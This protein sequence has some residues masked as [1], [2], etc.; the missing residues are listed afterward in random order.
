MRLFWVLGL[1]SLPSSALSSLRDHMNLARMGKHTFLANGLILKAFVTLWLSVDDSWICI[2]VALTSS[3]SVK[4]WH[5]TLPRFSR[6]STTY[7]KSKLFPSI[8]VYLNPRTF[9]L[10]KVCQ[11]LVRIDVDST[12][13]HPE[14]HQPWRFRRCSADCDKEPGEEQKRGSRNS[15]DYMGY[16][17]VWR[18]FGRILYVQEGWEAGCFIRH[19]W[20]SALASLAPSSHCS[21]GQPSRVHD[22]PCTAIKYIFRAAIAHRQ[23]TTLMFS[24]CYVC[25][26][27]LKSVNNNIITL[28]VTYNHKSQ[29]THWPYA[30]APQ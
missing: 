13:Y 20:P 7:K 23:I 19:V 24:L 28:L 6:L 9:T 12:L 15:C 5:V 2:L 11:C 29:T 3:S 22:G 30:L 27:T 17:Y 4:P 16:T 18:T 21:P 10:C 26:N 14:F 8:R 1:K 25:Q